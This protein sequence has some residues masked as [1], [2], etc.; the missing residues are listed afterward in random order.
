MSE[1]IKSNSN[2]ILIVA[3]FLVVFLFVGLRHYVGN[4]YE[5]YT[6]L[7]STIRNGVDTRLE[8]GFYLLNELFSGY[9]DGYKYVMLVSS[10]IVFS[11]LFI[12][13]IREKVLAL[14]IFFVFAFE[15]IF[16]INDQVRQGIAIAVFLY[17]IQFIEKREIY[18]YAFVMITAGVLFHYSALIMLPVYFMYRKPLPS[19]L[20]CAAII[21]SFLFYSR[22]LF[23]N[24][25]G[26]LISIIP[27]YGERFGGDSKHVVAIEKLGS[28]LA[29]M[30]WVVFGLYTAINQSKINRPLLTNIYLFGTVFFLITL[31]FHIITRVA[32]YL[33]YLKVLV[34]PIYIKNETNL[35]LKL[36]VLAAALLFFEL[37]I[38]LE[39]GTHGGYPYQ[40]IF[41]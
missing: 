1:R 20:W 29:V 12:T 3:S 7:F 17:A 22:G 32:F 37:E 18:K 10:F 24:I 9:S 14:G 39:L 38:F 11:F 21:V 4:D 31:D 19:W 33:V 41:N 23:Q 2:H 35:T 34:L 15:L 30:F 26:N 8:Y 40:T 16:L 28:G 5:A 13:F 27:F 25:L 6:Y 36:G